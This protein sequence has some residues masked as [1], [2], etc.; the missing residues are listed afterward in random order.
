VANRNEE[1]M[2]VN[3]ISERALSLPFTFD[4]TGNI[5]TT[6][7]QSKIWQ[8]K[9]RSAVGTILGERVMR[10]NFGSDVS[11]SQFDTV[12]EIQK[13]I[14]ENVSALFSSTFPTLEVKDVLAEYNVSSEELV[15][16]VEYMLPNQDEV[17]TQVGIATISGTQ[18]LYEE[19]L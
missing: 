10:S 16:S 1:K 4:S 19:N 7:D 9:V 3:V 2:T 17:K 6:L 14:E 15:V 13:T 11:F 18:P 8:D 5:A 12:G